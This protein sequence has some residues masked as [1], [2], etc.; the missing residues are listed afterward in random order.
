MS[1]DKKNSDNK[2]NLILINKIGKVNF[3]NKFKLEKIESHQKNAFQLSPFHYRFGLLS[4]A[5]LQCTVDQYSRFSRS[6]MVTIMLVDRSLKIRAHSRITFY[7]SSQ[8]RSVNFMKI[9]DQEFYSSLLDHCLKFVSPSDFRQ[10]IAANERG[11][12]SVA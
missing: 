9:T 7:V 12:C 11:S 10:R 8:L 6:L 1:V 5:S 2:I 4:S 3:N